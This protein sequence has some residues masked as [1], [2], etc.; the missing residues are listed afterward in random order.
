MHQTLVQT[1][2]CLAFFVLTFLFGPN[3]L[4]AQYTS[5]G[6]ASC[7]G[8]CCELTQDQ[9]GQA[10]AFF[11]TST[12]DLTMAFS[13][14]V[15]LNFGCKDA[16][17]ADGIVFIFAATPGLGVGGGGM[18]YQGLPQ[19]VGIEMDDYQN[20]GFG[21][22]ASDHMG[23][24][25]NGSVSHDLVGPVPLPNIEDCGYHCFTVNWNPATNNL[26]ATLDA[27]TISYSGDITAIVGSSAYF[28]FSSGT[29]SLSNIHAVCFNAPAV[30]PMD[31]VTICP[32]Q[33]TTLQADPSG[34]SWTW[35]AN[36][37]LSATNISNPTATPN[38]TTTY[39]VTINYA[40]GF[41]NTDDVTVMVATPP[42]ALATSNTPLCEGET[43]L[44]NASGGVGYNW[45]GPLGFGSG[46]QNPSIDNVVTANAGTY[47]VTV[48]DVD[49]CTASATTQVVI[50]PNPI[51]GIV[52]I[53]APLCSN[54][55][56]VTMQGIPAGGVWGGAANPLG[57][58][59]PTTLSPGLHTVTYTYTNANGCTSDTETTIEVVQAPVVQIFPAGPFCPTDP[60]TYMLAN[61]SG[62]F[63]TGVADPQ[64][65]VTPSSLP[66]GLHVVHYSFSDF[67][68]CTDEDEIL[69]E[70]QPS[71][72]VTIQPAGPFCPDAPVQTLT[73]NPVGG[74]WSGAANSNGQINPAVLGP[75]I[76]EVYYLFS[77]GGA[78]PGMDTIAVQIFTPPTA[79]ISGSGTICQGSGQSVN[80]TIATTGTGPFSVTYV[81]NNQNPV[82][83]TLPV[84][85]TAIPVSTPGTYTITDVVDAN[86]CHGTASGSAQ[87]QVV[88]SPTVSGLDFTCNGDNTAYSV[89]FVVSNG[90]PSTYT[91]TGIVP[92]VFTNSP[93]YT[94]NSGPIPNGANYSWVVNDTNNC[95]PVTLSGSFSC[96]CTTDAGTMSSNTLSACVGSTVTAT[97]NDDEV[98]DGNDSLIFVLHS[99]NGNSLGTVYG[100]NATGQFGLVPPM[101][102]GTT[103]YI[104]AVAGNGL[105][106]G[107]VDLLDPCLSVA[108]GQPVV[109]NALP[110][111]SISSNQEIC[112][113]EAATIAFALTGNAPFDVVYSDGS[114]NF[115][116]T[117]ILTG[118]TMSVSPS[119]TTTYSLVSTTDNNTPACSTNGGGSVTVTVWPHALTTQTLNICDGESIVLGGAPQ[120]MPG[121]Y[122]DSLTTVHG[123]DSIIVS[124]LI[125]NDLDTTYL[126]D[127]SCNPANVGTFTQNLTNQNG[128]DSTVILTVS[129]SLTDTTLVSSTTCDPVAAGVFTQILTTPEGCDSTVI[130]TVV[131]LPSD[132]TLLFD[133]SCN[134]ANVGS[135]VENLTNQNGCDSTVILTVSFSLTD[136]TLVS[137]TTC[138]PAAAGVFIQNLTTPEGCD[139]TV[140][141]TVALLPSDT[142]LLFGSSCNPASVGVFVQN[143]TNQFGCD[144]T[145]VRTVS[146]SLTDT[147]LVSSTTCDPTAAG[148]FIQ[149]LTTPEGCDSTVIET[150]ALLQSNVINLN[151]TSC[152]PANVGV[153]VQN[154][155]NQF[156]CDSTVTTTVTLLPS[157]TTTLLDSSCSPQDTGVV[158]Q[159]FSNQFGCDSTIVTIT[160]LVPPSQC[161]VVA[162]LTGSTI[163][164]GE[165]TGPL[166][167]TVT[168]GE[169][170]FN[171]A[172]TGP[173]S[174]SG[175]AAQVNVP[176]VIGNLP[177]G[178]YSVT[179]T[180]ANGLT[181]TATAVIGQIFPPTLTAQVTSDYNGFDV[182]CFGET[183]GSA[184]ASPVGGQAP[185]GFVWSNGGEQRSSDRPR[186]W[187][188]LGNSDGRQRLHGLQQCDAQRPRGT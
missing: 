66:P 2:H 29:G 17:G 159:I 45:S 25:S 132:T 109:F 8:T 141:E 173:Q 76:H 102:A 42:N 59:D 175:T 13:L 9:S 156:G 101:V 63:W 188:L 154:L 69:I 182:S 150:V 161:G 7:N 52:A 78:C 71:T 67:Y 115:T 99:S 73:A 187:Q 177:P 87:V 77:I 113:G 12:V 80:L 110:Q 147:T 34:S 57:Q 54:G 149:N 160:T 10:G 112:M 148:V 38:T 178:T 128:C 139:S 114:Q 111:A 74:I 75:G 40:C 121:N 138:D 53:N 94:F 50:N 23:I 179:V 145:V 116:L 170:P 91:I 183:D 140:I 27:T 28:G 146:F 36:P 97:H 142:T 131:L 46:L 18:G 22:P 106:N 126:T 60:P 1:L 41:S 48:T 5:F 168:L 133:T 130:E 186:H 14:S 98:L 123:C 21:D 20:G 65:L 120:T 44:L 151:N 167:L 90:D 47:T 32:G 11:S 72:P 125:V 153:F 89:T 96:Q 39:Y 82:T 26:T 37:T 68:G 180:A 171:Y 33:S 49:G 79:I 19:S 64:G 158:V 35:Q 58:V 155:T 136:T 92:G 51:V 84:G 185:F 86:G 93:P 85:S 88:G 144:S 122:T 134:P 61:P 4:R 83:L 143:L 164:C 152:D 127:A 169:P 137:S 6:S 81:V 31:D 129:F 181:T 3:A 55:P 95:N 118:H 119:A 163:P 107:N 15:S 108:F 172:W 24:N 30:I 165:T 174:G 62:G 176:Q 105:A 16:N 103:Y 166:T 117:N 184:S 135:F 104:S 124:T 56:I 157:D 70:I 162:S 100:S 43:L